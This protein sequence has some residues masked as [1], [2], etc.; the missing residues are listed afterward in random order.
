LGVEKV[1]CRSRKDDILQYVAG[2]MEGESAI[3]LRQHLASG[4]PECAGY[5]AEAEA[6]MAQL[7]LALDPI[8]PSPGLR[9]RLLKKIVES[10]PTASIPIRRDWDRVVLSAAVAAVLA[11]SVTLGTLWATNSLH[12]RHELD[13]RDFEIVMLQE[14]LAKSSQRV[15]ELE[16]QLKTAQTSLDGMKYTQMTGPTQPGA[17]GHAFID[18]QGGKWYFFTSGMNQPVAGKC[19]E[20]WLISDDKKM[21]AGTFEVDTNGTATLTGAIPALPPGTA[22]VTL[23]VTD[24]PMGGVSSPTGE[25]QIVGKIQFQ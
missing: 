12:P 24:E 5:V 16:V 4:C 25:A 22:G 21:P 14:T 19:Y 15:N 18:M 10:Y 3:E 1:D 9:Q 20:L 7:P 6:L 17:M 11:V 2:A 23:A 13:Q 8:A